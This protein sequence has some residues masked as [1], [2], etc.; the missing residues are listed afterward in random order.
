MLSF[1]SVIVFVSVVS[2]VGGGRFVCGDGGGF[3]RAG[4]REMS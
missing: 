1:A 3:L 2:L 4:R